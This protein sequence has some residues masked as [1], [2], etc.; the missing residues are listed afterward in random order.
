MTR[1]NVVPV[2]ELVDK[3]LLAEYRELPRVYALSKNW[4]LGNCPT[5]LPDTYRLGKGHVL[6]FYDKL[7][8]IFDRHAELFNE[9]RNRGFNAQYA[10]KAE[11]IKWAPKL[12]KLD[13][14]P[15]REALR[16]NRERIAERLATMRRP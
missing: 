11:Q 7:R 3:H 13:Y 5:E 6:F 1:I 16:L 4:F 9:C 12:M 2:S 10:P 14:T 15:T 8:F